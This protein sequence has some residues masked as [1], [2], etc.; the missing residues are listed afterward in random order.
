MDL[1][2]HT[3]ALQK[4]EQSAVEKAGLRARLI[5]ESALT[6]KGGKDYAAGFADVVLKDIGEE[7]MASA[8]LGVKLGEAINSASRAVPHNT[9]LNV[10]SVVVKTKSPAIGANS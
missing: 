1:R 6:G 8:A 5:D 9:T 7:V 3:L 2:E 10:K 4:V